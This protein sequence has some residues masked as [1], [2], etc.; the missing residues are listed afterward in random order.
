MTLLGP[1]VVMPY[2]TATLKNVPMY[3][4]RAIDKQ[5]VYEQGAPSACVGGSEKLK[6]KC[7]C[8][9]A[10]SPPPAKTT[11]T[12]KTVSKSKSALMSS[13]ALL[14]AFALGAFA[15]AAALRISRKRKLKKAAKREQLASERMEE[16]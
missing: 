7:G 11:C 14:L 10:N 3:E 16:E 2:G 15:Y 4:G 5:Y 12:C 13:I 8:A 1:C 6:A 9:N